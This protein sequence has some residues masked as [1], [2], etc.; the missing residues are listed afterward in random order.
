MPVVGTT[1]SGAG[2]VPAARTLTAGEGLD[3]GGDLTA[4][5]TFTVEWGTTHTQV[6][7]GDDGAYSDSRPWSEYVEL[8]APT[9]GQA[10]VWDSTTGAYIPASVVTN[11]TGSF[12]VTP[13]KTAAYTLSPGEYVPCDT[14]GGAFMITL[15]TNPSSGTRVGWKTVNGTGTL[16]V[17]RGGSTDVFTRVGSGTTSVTATMTG[18]GAMA[19]YDATNHVWLIQADDLPLAQLDARYVLAGSS[20]SPDATTSSKGVVQLAGDLAGT[21]TAPTVPGLTSRV[22][23]SQRGPIGGV[24]TPTYTTTTT[25]DASL[26]S[27]FRIVATS[28]LTL[29]VPSNGTDGQRVL[30][31]VQMTNATAG[32]NRT[33]TMASGY[34]LGGN[35][36]ARTV[37]VATQSTWAYIGVIYRNGTWR[38]LATD[39]T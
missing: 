12:T 5:R 30:F 21:A 9:N 23:T 38:L 29:N 1:A 24:Q 36:T 17:S 35:V 18:Q 32:A 25:V 37:V 26:G 16:T 6:R 14:S 15:P 13:V 39:S 3:G 20:S 7:H 8:T 19:Q 28:A 4:D 27:H 11:S 10:P 2:N 31:E 22:P 33:I 34:E